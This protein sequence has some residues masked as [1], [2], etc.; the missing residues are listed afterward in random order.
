MKS[1]G[2]QVW[3]IKAPEFLAVSV[4]ISVRHRIWGGG[5]LS[6]GSSELKSCLGWSWG[7]GDKDCDCLASSIRR[8]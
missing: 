5:V 1:S 3:S 8:L 6:I 4:F 7:W 2:T